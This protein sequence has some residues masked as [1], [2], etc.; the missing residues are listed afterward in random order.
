MIAGYAQN[1][2]FEKALQTFKQMQLSDVKPDSATF[3]SILRACATM[4]ALEEGMDIHQS[5]VENG[6][7]SNII[8]LSVL[9]CMYEKCGRIHKA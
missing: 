1:G 4:G 2:F 3:A 7:A 5:V 9:I 6:F 8:I